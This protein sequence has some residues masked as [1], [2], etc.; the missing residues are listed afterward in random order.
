MG[1]GVVPGRQPRNGALDARPSSRRQ[2][3]CPSRLMRLRQVCHWSQHR[4]R[5]AGTQSVPMAWRCWTVGCA[6]WGSGAPRF[7]SLRHRPR[8]EHAC[9]DEAPGAAFHAAPCRYLADNRDTPGAV[10]RGRRDGRYRL[11]GLTRREPPVRPRRSASADEPQRM[12][13]PGLSRVGAELEDA[14][15]AARSSPGARALVREANL[16]SG[17][18][19]RLPRKYRMKSPGARPAGWIRCAPHQARDS[20]GPRQGAAGERFPGLPDSFH[21][22]PT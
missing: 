7:Q 4:R 11:A 13:L 17:C 10:R 3:S 9:A 8:Q 19:L 22:S 6:P 16:S 1:E 21:N 14:G 12:C 15:V 20:R 2:T 18:L 5:G